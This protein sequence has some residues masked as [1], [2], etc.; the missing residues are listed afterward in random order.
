MSDHILY[1]EILQKKI[2]H[3]LDETSLGEIICEMQQKGKIYDKF[4]IINPIYDVKNFPKDP[5][6]IHPK[7]C[8]DK[9]CIPEDQSILH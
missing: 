6:E 2:C 9:S 5:L 1:T 8:N 3:H 4:K 7:T